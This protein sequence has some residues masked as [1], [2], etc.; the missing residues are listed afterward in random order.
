MRDI[1]IDKKKVI[2]LIKDIK[3]SYAVHVG[4]FEG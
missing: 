2:L 3:G 1:F 4:I